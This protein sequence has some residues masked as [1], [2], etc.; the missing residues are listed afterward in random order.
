MVR[1]AGASYQYLIDCEVKFFVRVDSFV[2]LDEMY[3]TTYEGLVIY[4]VMKDI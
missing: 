4:V 2:V 3:W 1:G